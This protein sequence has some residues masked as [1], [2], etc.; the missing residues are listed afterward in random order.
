MAPKIVKKGPFSYLQRC[1]GLETKAIEPSATRRAQVPVAASAAAAVAVAAAVA[2]PPEPPPVPNLLTREPLAPVEENHSDSDT[3]DVDTGL[4]VILP[5][6][7]K[8]VTIGSVILVMSA[9]ALATLL[10]NVD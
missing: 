5:T 3:I 9:I 4:A 7:E 10:M 8:R 1:C 6:E 2:A